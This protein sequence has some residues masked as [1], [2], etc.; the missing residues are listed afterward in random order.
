M[1]DTTGI[2]GEGEVSKSAKFDVSR[3]KALSFDL[4]D[5][6][7]PIVPIIERA[8]KVS[9]A[10]L[11]EH[12]PNTQVFFDTQSVLDLRNEVFVEFP[13]TQYD[14]TFL[15]KECI[16]R[17]FEQCGY[18]RSGVEDA[19]AVFKYERDTID[20][21]DD[22][23]PFF[24][25]LDPAMIKIALTNGNASLERTPLKDTFHTYLNAMDVKAAKPEAPMFERALSEHNLAPD[26]ML[27]IGDCLVSDIHGAAELGIPTVWMNRFARDWQE[28]HARPNFVVSSLNQLSHILSDNALVGIGK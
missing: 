2:N 1:S 14:L 24:E 10:W 17:I 11:I 19:F 5:T 3:I 8:E 15:R 12:Y 25:Q 4:D 13:A 9:R 16:G 22:V 18:D 26:E 28:Q 20:L 7:W 21:C 23:M 6:L 27:H